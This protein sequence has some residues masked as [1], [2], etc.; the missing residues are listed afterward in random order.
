MSQEKAHEIMEKIYEHFRIYL[1]N[2]NVNLVDL[3]ED[4]E[5]GDGYYNRD[6]LS[7]AFSRVG[8]SNLGNEHEERMEAVF[9]I[10]DQ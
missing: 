8:L 3:F 1:A 2:N 5:E 9:M 10:F 4:Q 6:E 7:Q